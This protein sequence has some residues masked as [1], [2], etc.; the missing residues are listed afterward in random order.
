MGL[1]QAETGGVVRQPLE[2]VRQR[3]RSNVPLRDYTEITTRA[4]QEHREG[5]ILHQHHVLVSIVEACAPTSRTSEYTAPTSSTGEYTATTACTG[6][7]RAPISCTGEYTAPTS[8]TGEYTAP[9]SCTDKYMAPT[10][11]TGEYMA[12]TSCTC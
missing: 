9:T 11:C 8:C 6:E 10:S 7:Y 12:T 5:H 1:L 3:V 2:P 4:V